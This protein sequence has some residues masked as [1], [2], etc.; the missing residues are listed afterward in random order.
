M[1]FSSFCLYNSTVFCTI[2]RGSSKNWATDGF[3]GILC[4]YCQVIVFV[5]LLSLLR[6]IV[7]DYKKWYDDKFLY[8]F[9]I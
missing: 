8:I 3:V 1:I 9:F 4:D 2:F 6:I 5:F 7:R